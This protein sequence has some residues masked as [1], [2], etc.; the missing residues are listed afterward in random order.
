MG[1]LAAHFPA[2]GDRPATP[3]V[4]G[5][6][7]VEAAAQ[8]SLFLFPDNLKAG[9]L[10]LNRG[11]EKVKFRHQVSPDSIARIEAWVVDGKKI[12]SSELLKFQFVIWISSDNNGGMAKAADG[13]I[14]GTR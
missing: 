9:N 13:L 4:P 2:K 12:G 6:L 3:I 10:P 5:T 14:Y 1:I 7:L 8:A 11:L